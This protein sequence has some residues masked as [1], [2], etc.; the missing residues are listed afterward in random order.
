MIHQWL[1]ISRED[2]QTE[3]LQCQQEG[4]NLTPLEV[5]FKRVE[6][7]NLEDKVHQLAAEN[8][9]DRTISLPVS[10]A[11]SYN[12][13][14]GLEEIRAVR[15]KST[16]KQPNPPRKALFNKVYGGWLGRISG[17]LLGKPVELWRSTRLWGYLRETGQYP[18]RDYISLEAPEET[19]EKYK[20]DREG[21]FIENVDHMP[22]DDDTNYTTINLA[23][24]KRNGRGF[25][26]LNV[27][28]LWL[29]EMPILHTFTAERVAY[30]NLCLLIQPPASATHRN[31][32]REWIG[33][34]IRADLWGYSAPGNPKLAAEYAWR[35]ACISHI[36]NGIYGEM[37]VAAMIAAAFSTNDVLEI[38]ESGLNQIPEDSR[39]AGEIRE[40]M[41]WRNEGVE[42]DDAV[43]RIH[44][45]WDEN[46]AHD[47]C[48]TISNARIV[49]LSLLWG[50]GD[51]SDSI[52]KAVQPGFDTD[53]NGAT[54]GSIMGIIHGA[55]K[56]PTKWTAPLND[57]LETGVSGY[58][59]VKIRDMAE[60]TLQLIETRMNA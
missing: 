53:C 11:Y 36:K 42:Y 4:K 48:H 21:C 41:K 23:V 52:T 49:A 6:N 19:I 44:T 56:I 18:L 45:I 14:S 28:D 5:E 54:V 37:W 9:L 1:Y 46:R 20:V 29:Q 10:D 34:Q 33:A 32:H 16:T 30:R 58:H 60:E 7:L 25:T 2:L 22:E 40:M 35:D 27:A 38:I 8:L 17:C 15:P 50:C 57:T 39:L 26:P 43:R 47:W 13:P 3:W 55:S 59:R 31:P 51:F 24:M 12:E